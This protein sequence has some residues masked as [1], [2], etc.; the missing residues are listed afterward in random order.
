MIVNPG[1]EFASEIAAPQQK[2]TDNTGEGFSLGLDGKE[3]ALEGKQGDNTNRTLIDQHADV[4]PYQL[5]DAIVQGQTLS[6]VLDQ[7]AVST[8]QYVDAQPLTSLTTPT[9]HVFDPTVYQ[10]P[11]IIDPGSELTLS[12]D[13]SVVVLRVVFE[14][15][16]E[17]DPLLNSFLSYTQSEFLPTFERSISE[18]NLLNGQPLQ[19]NLLTSIHS[20]GVTQNA[21][22]IV[23]LSVRLLPIG[24]HAN[25]YL[26][27]ISAHKVQSASSTLSSQSNG[28][29]NALPQG[30]FE[31][32]ALGPNSGF[33]QRTT[34]VTN[35]TVN[36]LFNQPVQTDSSRVTR[37]IEAVN[38]SYLLTGEI[39]KRN[40][41]F[42]EGQDGETLWYRD[43]EIS[44][45]NKIELEKRLN[46]SEFIKNHD[47]QR[48]FINGELLWNRGGINHD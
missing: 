44:E 5:S 17:S 1:V 23:D 41:L 15:V 31:P 48:V 42:T 19:P 33:A 3:A 43:F 32:P 28:R 37:S 35:Q 11:D 4:S 22:G 21:D 30:V 34:A 2:G 6:V 9:K 36:T 40:I 27:N 13:N 14:G 25:H 7:T 16:S 20:L 38:N 45:E 29:N 12:L 46:T 47:I 8:D 39:A 24:A 26:S 18:F 10:A